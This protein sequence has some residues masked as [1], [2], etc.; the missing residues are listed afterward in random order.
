MPREEGERSRYVRRVHLSKSKLPAVQV[1]YSVV[2]HQLRDI[3][4]YTA[5]SHTD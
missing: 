5:D 4:H 1:H 3:K 2:T